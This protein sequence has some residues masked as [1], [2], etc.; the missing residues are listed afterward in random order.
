MTDDNGFRELL[1]RDVVMRLGVSRTWFADKGGMGPAAGRLLN[2]MLATPMYR[3]HVDPYTGAVTCKHDDL[4]ETFKP[5]L[6][7][8]YDNANDLPDWCKRKLAVLML[9]NYNE[10]GRPDIPGIGQRITRDVF[11]VFTSEEDY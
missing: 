4:L 8:V 10:A 5:R 7:P 11:W 6:K 1:A 2:M 3:L 9:V